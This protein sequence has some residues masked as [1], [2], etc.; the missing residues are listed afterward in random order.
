[1]SDFMKSC[2]K[3]G[4]D[5]DFIADVYF[6]LF[7]KS[8]NGHNVYLA[9]LRCQYELNFMEMTAGGNEISPKFMV[10]YKASKKMDIN[11]YPE[12]TRETFLLGMKS[13]SIEKDHS[14]PSRVNFKS[15]L[16]YIDAQVKYWS[17][18]K[19]TAASAP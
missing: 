12:N 1:M 13:F 14:K 10:N 8:L 11:A 17:R 3:S 15:K 4:N 19:S 5:P 2:D 16:E 6:N 18:K 7:K 9:K